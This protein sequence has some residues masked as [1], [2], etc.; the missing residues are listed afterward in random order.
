MKALINEIKH[1]LPIHM[2]SLKG[3]VLGYLFDHSFRF[4]FFLRIGIYFSKSNNPI[5]RLLS[6]FIRNKIMYQYSSDVSFNIKVGKNVRFG[7]PTGIVIGN[8]TEIGDNVKI[9]QHVTFGSHGKNGL[10]KEYPIIGNNVKI[11]AGA[12]VIGGIFVGDNSIIGAN[13]VVNVDIP[14]NSIAVGIPCKV[15]EKKL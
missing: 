14:S 7:H 15:F 1:D 13:S 11:F 4:L 2:K 10:K 12:K 9:W 6:R 3:F 8:K 5:L